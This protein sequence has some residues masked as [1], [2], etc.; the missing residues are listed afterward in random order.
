MP[1]TRLSINKRKEREESKKKRCKELVVKIDDITT[2]IRE[3]T[4]E[5]LTLI[6]ETPITSINLPTYKYKP[7]MVPTYVRSI[8]Y[9]AEGIYMSVKDDYDETFG[10][11]SDD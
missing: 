11:E 3:L 5:A 4:D 9:G 1:V 6:E 10:Y 8:H 2:K 7:Y